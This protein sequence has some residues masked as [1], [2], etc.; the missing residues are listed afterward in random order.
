MY[1]SHT[2]SKGTIASGIY[3]R[4]QNTSTDHTTRNQFQLNSITIGRSKQCDIV[5]ENESV[6]RFHARI[7]QTQDGLP[8]VIDEDS[9]NGTW[10]CRNG[11]WIRLRIA[12]LG[13]LDRVRF[14]DLEL[15]RN[16]ILGKLRGTFVK[17]QDVIEANES[18]VRP[19]RNPDT[20][21]IEE[22]RG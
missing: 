21:D 16:L 10:L 5:I 15:D 22:K 6:S 20:G 8:V 13:K 19:R 9:H 14:G 18:L 2:T 11:L 7:E 17:P 4:W 12:R 1:Y 3:C